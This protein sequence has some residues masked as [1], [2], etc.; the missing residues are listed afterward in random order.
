MKPDDD[1][2]GHRT[3]G[4]AAEHLGERVELFLQR[5][6]RPCDR[7]VSMV[8]IWPIWVCMPVAVTTIEPVPRVTEVFWNS[9]FV[10]SPSATS[11]EASGAASLPI[12]Q[13]GGRQQRQRNAGA[14]ARLRPAAI[15]RRSRSFLPHADRHR[16]QPERRGGDCHRYRG[17]LDQTRRRRHRQD[18]QA[19][20]RFWHRR[21]WRYRHHRARLLR[22]ERI[23]ALGL[24]TAARSMRDVGALGLD[25]MRR[26][27]TRPRVC[28]HVRQSATC[29]TS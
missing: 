11:A 3:P 4:D 15:R 10:R 1:D 7:V 6:T 27:R 9:M 18:W 5:R 23:S 13:R 26:V 19:S 8:A 22:G 24:G 12:R 20:D 25:Q 2:Y 21:A 16:R 29:T 28:R 14:A 17:K